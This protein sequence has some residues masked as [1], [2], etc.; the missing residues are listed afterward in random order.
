GVPASGAGADPA[1]HVRRAALPG[2]GDGDLDDTGRLQRGGG[3]RAAPGD[4]ASE[5]A[6]AAAGDAEEAAG[7]DG[8]PWG[9]AGGG[10]PDRRR[11]RLFLELRLPGE[12]RVELRADRV[13]DGVPEGALSGRVLH[14]VAERVAD[15]VLRALHA[16]AS[17]DTGWGD[18]AAA[19]PEARRM[20]L[21][22]GA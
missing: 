12:P 6:G 3:R 15:G 7:P 16:G 11:P 22:V 1:P 9:G 13:R 2:A 8:G 4:G 21:H 17:G 18:G 10:R 5:E 20:G 19:V 14:G